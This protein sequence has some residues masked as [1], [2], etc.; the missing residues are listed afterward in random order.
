[1]TVEVEKSVVVEDEIPRPI[2]S[3]P[4]VIP[5]EK[6]VGPLPPPP[7]APGMKKKNS[8]IP[9]I[10]ITPDKKK[11][12][13]S[14]DGKISGV[15]ITLPTPVISEIP[16]HSVSKKN[17]VINSTPDFSDLT[18]EKKKSPGIKP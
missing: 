15:S 14:M 9:P 5:I 6:T 16:S 1:M 7:M 12:N 17:I 13:V 10:P 8:S 4:G 18:K 11:K 2:A 3:K